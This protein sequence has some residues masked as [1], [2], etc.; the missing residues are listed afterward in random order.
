M[1]LSEE[2]S[3]VHATSIVVNFTQPVSVNSGFLS[4]GVGRCMSLRAGGSNTATTKRPTKNPIK[5]QAG[6]I[7][8]IIFYAVLNF[9]GCKLQHWL[10][11]YSMGVKSRLQFA[12]G[13]IGL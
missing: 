6:T 2:A 12:T 3:G 11:K 8:I 5:I 9:P 7:I 13:S 4:F 1:K 10:E